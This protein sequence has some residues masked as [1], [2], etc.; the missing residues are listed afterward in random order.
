VYAGVYYENIVINKSI[1]LKGQNRET[2]IID[3]NHSGDV[4]F[5]DEGGRVNISG[6]TIQNSGFVEYSKHDA[7]IE[8]T[9]DG[10]NVIDNI[11]YNNSIGVYSSY[12][13]H[14]TY[15][16]NIFDMNSGYGMYLYTSSDYAI[17]ME[18]TFKNN[19]CA[20][21]IKGS[22]HNNVT[23]NIFLDNDE[24]MYF[25]CGARLN[26]VYHNTFIN[27]SVWNANDYV[28]GNEWDAGYPT[29]G[30]YWDDYNGK[31]EYTG[32]DQ[33]VLGTDGIGDTAYNITK[34]GAK[35]DN[36][37]LMEPVVAP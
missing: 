29:G 11:F 20:L 32:V 18:N 36:Y 10:N 4:V 5:I 28:G 12:A 22:T 30:N 19:Y 25:C 8:I 34:D 31:D 37:P 3:G 14:N 6:F 1:V 35:I 2:T 7:G 17:T 15:K 23:K 9:S 33:D 13:D 16:Q 21:R 24:G 26:T 27:N